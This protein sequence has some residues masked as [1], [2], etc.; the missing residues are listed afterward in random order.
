MA[1]REIGDGREIIDDFN[2]GLKAIKDNGEY[3][4]IFNRFRK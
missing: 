3:L 1:S 2:N 4:R